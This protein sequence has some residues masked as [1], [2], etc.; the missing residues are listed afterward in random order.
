[1]TANL[2]SAQVKWA[3]RAIAVLLAPLFI[4]ALA[5][6]SKGPAVQQEDGP[7]A[8]PLLYEIARA[9][10]AV[11]GWML[12]TIHALPSGTAWRT[13]VINEVIQGADLLVVEI[14]K[15]T[16]RGDGPSIY[17]DLAQ[18]PGLP[19]LAERLPADLRPRLASIM[20][21]GRLSPS[22][23]APFETWAAAIAL[24][25]V[26]ATGDPAYGAD[27]ALIEAFAGRPVRELEGTRAQ[28]AIFDRLSETTQRTMLAAVVRESERA[29]KDPDRLQRAWLAGDAALIE[30]STREGILADQALREALLTGRN[31]RWV[32]AL[33]PLLEQRPRPLIAVGTAHL[34]GPEGLAALLEAEGYRLRRLP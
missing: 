33:V 28:L 22:E 30:Q 12:G 18:S 5:G 20:K 19:P 9:D 11:E 4:L 13:P 21:R 24:A 27:R 32:T 23:L 16:G 34:V 8:N 15:P 7:P 10:G 6:C 1:M 17:L 25:R 14:G 31:R 2:G 26:D 29:Q 3:R